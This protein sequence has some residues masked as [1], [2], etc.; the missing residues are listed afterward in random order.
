MFQTTHAISATYA[1]GAVCTWGLSDFIGGYTA[2]RFDSFFLASLSHLSGTVFVA[3]LA[4][5]AGRPFPP[6]PETGWALAAGVSGGLSLALFYQALS[7]G[8]MG[9][10]AP[11][12]AVLSALIPAG[13]GI[14]TQGIPGLRPTG[15][16]LLALA[17]IWLIS[18]PDG[19]HRPEGLG[20]AVIAGFGFALF[21]IF[22]ER[23]GAGAALWLATVSRSSALVFTGAVTV[24]ARRF[25]PVYPLG[26]AWGLLA[27]AIDVSGTVLFVRAA[28]TGPL[29]TAVILSSLYPVITVLL[30][31][32]FLREHFT[33]SRAAGVVAAIAAIPMLMAG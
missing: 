5:F 3:A 1:L 18:R 7:R 14:L 21:Y 6:F 2:R 20:L 30:A 16:F 27:G 22:M 11:V 12:A 25:S 26:F 33:R 19:G 24:A 29:A 28:Q 10:A 8:N 17:A 9:L 13:F 31:R 23:A 4:L 15:G 32:V